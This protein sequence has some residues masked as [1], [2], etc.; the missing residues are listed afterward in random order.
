MDARGKDSAPGDPGAHHPEPLIEL[1]DSVLHVARR[2]DAYRYRDPGIAPLTPLERLV[3]L[4]V[5]RRPGVSPT[6]LANDLA[7]RTSNAS[8]AL[9]GL[10]AKGLVDRAADPADRRSIR[11]H[12]TP[13][14]E[15]GLALVHREWRALFARHALTDEEM[16]TAIDVLERIDE[17]I[18]SGPPEA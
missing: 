15:E 7:L 14:A 10:A 16:R 2:L 5:R 3:L 13:A 8:T 1:I 11:L 18:Q 12:L 6:T 9:R 4:Y 17:A